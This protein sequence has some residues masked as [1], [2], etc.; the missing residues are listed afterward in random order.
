[1]GGILILFVFQQR[2]DKRLRGEDV[3]AH[4]GI[5]HVRVIRGRRRI[6]RLLDELRD[7]AHPIR[8]NAAKGGSLRARDA[9]TR[10]RAIQ[11][12]G[13]VLFHHLGRV[14]AV[15]VVGAEDDDIVRLFVINQVQRLQDG[16]GR[17]V[18]PALTTTL[19]SRHG[20][21]VLRGGSRQVPCLGNVAVQRM[22]LVLGQHRNLE[23]TGVDK[24]GQH[25]IDQAIGTAE[26][27]GGLSAVFRQRKKALSLTAGKDNGK[28]IWKASHI[29]QS[30]DVF[31]IAQSKSAC[32]YPLLIASRLPRR[33]T[34]HM[35][36][37]GLA[38]AVDN[39]YSGG[40]ESRNFF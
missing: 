38:R 1:M 40:Y 2:V 18:V 16:I 9:D 22:G 36:S 24:I 27:N 35:A 30:I 19:L 34:R 4:R 23:E 3:V 39:P 21:D 8:L 5:G 33:P 13:D 28:D 17:T 20:S 31:W 6:G 32:F 25:E 14:H 10:H 26:R 11:T 37:Q 15:D 12:G 7:R 29:T